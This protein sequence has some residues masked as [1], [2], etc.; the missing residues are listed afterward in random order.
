MWIRYH[1]SGS[2]FIVS[3][4]TAHDLIDIWNNSDHEDLQL[5]LD[6]LLERDSLKANDHRDQALEINLH[7]CYQS[8]IEHSDIKGNMLFECINKDGISKL[9][10]CQSKVLR[11]VRENDNLVQLIG[12][13]I[14]LDLPMQK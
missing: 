7:L 3:R 11:V 9:V 4:T 1:C 13:M 12:G 6:A 8:T 10:W 14:P 2:Q 5:R